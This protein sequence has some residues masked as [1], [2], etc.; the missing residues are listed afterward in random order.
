VFSPVPCEHP[1]ACSTDSTYPGWT[2]EMGC[3]KAPGEF[4]GA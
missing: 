4:D 2:P 3:I 1:E